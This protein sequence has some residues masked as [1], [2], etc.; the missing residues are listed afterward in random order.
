VANGSAVPAPLTR[1]PLARRPGLGPTRALV[2]LRQTALDRDLAAGVD[3]ESSA[4][5]ALRAAQ[6]T[7]ARN[8]RRLADGIEALLARAQRPATSGSAIRPRAN[9]LRSK[10]VFVALQGRLRSEE[11]L[12]PQGIALLKQ[13]LTD[14]ASPLYAVGDPETFS[15]VLRV[16]AAALTDR[17]RGA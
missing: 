15:S 11:R 17:P 5:L 13:L 4:Q 3:P 9:V 8:R 6:L 1:R 12:A 2:L 16:V 14:V 10:A 7:S